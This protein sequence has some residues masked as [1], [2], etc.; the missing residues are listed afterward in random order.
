[1]SKTLPDAYTKNRLYTAT[2]WASSGRVR[3]R[4]GRS[5][6]IQERRLLGVGPQRTARIFNHVAVFFVEPME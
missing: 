4:S 6:P 2:V 5:E 1:M 3:S